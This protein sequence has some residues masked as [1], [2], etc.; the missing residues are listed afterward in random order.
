MCLLT[1]VL[2]G[3]QVLRQH[4]AALQAADDAKHA[5]AHAKNDLESYIIARRSALQVLF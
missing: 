5:A 3:P 4:M 2:F 1:D